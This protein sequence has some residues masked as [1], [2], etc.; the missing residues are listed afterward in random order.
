MSI[1]KK[2]KRINNFAT[3]FC[4]ETG[5]AM[6]DLRMTVVS[7][8]AHLFV[9]LFR[10]VII[11]LC[12][13]GCTGLFV[14]SFELP[15]SMPL[16]F[17]ACLFFSLVIACLYY[18]K[19]LFNVGYIA[20]FFFFVALSIFLIE[21]AN[22]GMNAVL[23]NV[24]EVADAK[25]NLE[26]VRHYNE[27]IADRNMTITACLLL[28]NGLG[29]CFLNSAV[30]GYRSSGLLF[31]IL[32][33]ALQICMY[34][35]DSLNYFYLGLVIVGFL[36][37]LY[38][39]YSKCMAISFDKKILDIKVKNKHIFYGSKGEKHPAVYL[40]SIAVFMTLMFSIVSGLLVVI[41]PFSLK[42][43]YSQMKDVTDPYVEEF[44]MN[45][46][47][48]YF[49]QYEATG[50]MSHGRLGGVRAISMDFQTDL[51]ISY[52]PY[53][54]ETLYL[55]GY[56]GETYEENQWLQYRKSHKLL[57]GAP[58]YLTDFEALSN[59]EATLLEHLY[60]NGEYYTA[61]ARF[62]I[63]NVGASPLY[64]YFPYNTMT[65]AKVF[66]T[67]NYT[68]Y[69]DII[70]TG[71]ATGRIYTVDYY[72]LFEQA[73]DQAYTLE[74]EAAYREY[75]YDKYLDVPEQL[76]PLLDEICEENVS[77]TSLHEI[78]LELQRYFY[79]NY[80]YSLS[81]GVT[82][83]HKD[84]VEYFVTR[85]K[86]G[87][88]AHFA[89]TG[90]LLLRNMGI[91]ARYVEG[92]AVDINAVD[93]ADVIEEDWNEWYDGYNELISADED[94]AAALRIEVTDGSAHAWVEV[95]LDGFGWVPVEFTIAEEAEE[96]TQNGFWNRFSGIFSAGDDS[97]RETIADFAEQLK[98]SFP[99]IGIGIV[100]FVVAI[101]L[102][103]AIR[104]GSLKWSLY[105]RKSNARLIIQYKVLVKLLR[106]I[107]DS[108]EQKNIYHRQLLDFATTTLHLDEPLLCYY[109]ELV[110]CA[111]YSNETLTPEQLDKATEIYRILLKAMG[112]CR[113]GVARYWIRIR[114]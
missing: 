81:P 40:A 112:D 113:R 59:K 101:L 32:Y 111:G 28:I 107:D 62:Q 34:F 92:Y 3:D 57:M 100:G 54:Y 80:T 27:Q 12:A 84:F 11:F 38:M 43:N 85:Q 49:N 60:A 63:Q 30:S 72:P 75:V 33:P 39:Q 20:F 91:P 2:E 89:T 48:G 106:T 73:L 77:A 25:F 1:S 45:G 53:S 82:P 4:A 108:L 50:G 31:V 58:Y 22:S 8:R 14:T 9:C 44:A 93:E 26:G 68:I 79:N 66:G 102:I 16:L 37:M 94:E 69:G 52:V 109:I 99:I 51:I 29:V 104:I 76:K 87:Y 10:A 88:C 42:S 15:C 35:D 110:E 83:K 23:N 47:F 7:G 74:Q 46:I 36:M 6:E 21:W 78:I 105:Y 98:E 41:S 103:F 65:S 18:G 95:Y 90:A 13:F 114:Y 64:C 97:D 70:N 24:M 55:R 61:K 19:V 67:N 96:E 56:I 71:L 5:I 86:S 17:C